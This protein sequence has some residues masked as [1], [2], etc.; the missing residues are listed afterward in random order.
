MWVVR[1]QQEPSYLARN[2]KYVPL[3]YKFLSTALSRWRKRP[4]TIPVH[5]S[6]YLEIYLNVLF[7]FIVYTYFQ[8]INLEHLSNVPCQVE[9][10]QFMN[11]FD[12]H[13]NGPA[14]L[15]VHVLSLDQTEQKLLAYTLLWTLRFILKVL[16]HRNLRAHSTALSSAVVER[17]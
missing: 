9:R 16:V 12:I 10:Q 5:F 15:P 1:F 17:V 7:D 13:V 8:T 2:H 14:V 4:F 11:K 3:F 6:I